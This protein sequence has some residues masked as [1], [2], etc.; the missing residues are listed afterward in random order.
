MV[1]FISDTTLTIDN[2]GA[3]LSVRYYHLREDPLCRYNVSDISAKLLTNP[4]PMASRDSRV[5]KE[6]L[7][8][9]E[10]LG[11]HDR[12]YGMLVE[13]LVERC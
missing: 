7:E 2:L 5:Q 4:G 13:N 10:R 9:L 8:T 11:L 1:C 6:A 3:L 12:Y